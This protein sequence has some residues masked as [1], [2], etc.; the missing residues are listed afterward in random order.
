MS[1]DA[2][3][4]K[5]RV[6]AKI[7]PT[8]GHAGWRRNLDLSPPSSTD[9]EIRL[10]PGVSASGTVVDV[11]TGRPI[12]GAEVCVRAKDAS[13][14]YGDRIQTTTD[15]HGEF[16][17]LNTLDPI[18]Y[19]GLVTDT[20]AHGTAVR[21]TPGSGEKVRYPGGSHEHFLEGGSPDRVE[22]RVTIRQGSKLKP[23][24]AE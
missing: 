17:F 10:V 20:N 16:H 13:N 12:P 21:P 4:L 14:A 15:A 7:A 5:F 22:W 23:L 2:G 1:G 9:Y 11:D 24:P 8:A 18:T 3:A 6:E 19:L